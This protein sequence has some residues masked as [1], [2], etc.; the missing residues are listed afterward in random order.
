MRQAVTIAGAQ[1]LR[2]KTMRPHALPEVGSILFATVVALL[3]PGP[4][5][6]ALAQAQGQEPNPIPPQGTAVSTAPT[7]IVQPVPGAMAGSD[8]VPSTISEK[9]ASDDSLPTLAYRL[10][11]LTEEQRQAI[12][13]SVAANSAQPSGTSNAAPVVVGTVIPHS[14][15]LPSVAPELG[16][17]IPAVKNLQF[18]VRREGLVLIDP[19][20]HAVLAVIPRQ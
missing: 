8:A 16:D 15:G 6:N 1:H 12:A 18:D 7:N 20:Q 14:E 4:V 9:N 3:I 13:R 5:G 11:N 19:L 17:R 2:S 10:R